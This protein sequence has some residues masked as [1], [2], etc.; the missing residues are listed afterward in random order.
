M[1]IK[2]AHS[3]PFN[4]LIAKILIFALTISCL[5]T[6]KLPWFMDLTFQVPMQYYSLQHRSL[7][8]PPDRFTAEHCFCLGLASSFFLE[9]LL[10]SFPV[11]YWIPTDL[12]GSSYRVIS[13]LP[14]HSVHGVSRQE[15]WSGLSFSSPVDHW[16]F[17]RT[18]H[19][20]YS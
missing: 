5:T 7:L 4:S 9:L 17:I 8:S 12:G 16:S 15:Y 3:H 19:H 13:F 20:D 10:L 11:A 18:L 2:F 6:S 14:F 1:W